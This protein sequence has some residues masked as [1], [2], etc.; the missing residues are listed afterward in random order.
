MDVVRTAV[1]V[2]GAAELAGSGSVLDASG[3]VDDN[4]RRSVQLFAALPAIVAYGQR[5]R[6]GLDVVEPRDDLDYAANFLWMTFGEE[7]DEVVVDAFNRSMILYAEHSFNASTFTARVVTS[8]LTDLY[9]AVVAAIGALKG[10]LHGGANEAVMHIF[11]EIGDAA[12]VPAWLDTALG[13][14]AQD[15]GLRAPRLQE[16]RLPGA[17]HEGRA[18]QPRR[19]LRPARRPRAVHGAGDASSCRARGSTRTSTTRRGRPTTSSA[20]TRRRSRR[21]SSRR[22]SPAGRRTSSSRRRRTRSSARSRSTSARTSG[23]STATCPP[24]HEL[25]VADRAGGARLSALA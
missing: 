25:A 11:D 22:G 20:S 15:H 14:E 17:D 4:L 16:R 23:T 9:S 1:S 5:R 21:S 24:P 12:N 8:T 19:A 3:S 2:L 18:R 7:S 13:R 6:R 10:P